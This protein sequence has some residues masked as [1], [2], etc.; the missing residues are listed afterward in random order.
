MRKK[1]LP[2]PVPH[3]PRPFLVPCL[4]NQDHTTRGVPG[5][6]ARDGYVEIRVKLEQS[7]EDEVGPKAVRSIRPTGAG[8]LAVHHIEGSIIVL[9]RR[10]RR[11]CFN[12]LRDMILR[13]VFGGGGSGGG[14]G[15][16]GSGGD[17]GDGGGGI[18]FEAFS[19]QSTR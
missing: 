4:V 8:L 16:G 1:H 10:H 19:H 15:G 14:G 7:S 13:G 9:R 11:R 6:D 18:R 17:R 3:R 2:Q 5:E 12:H